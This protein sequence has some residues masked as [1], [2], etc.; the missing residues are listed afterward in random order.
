MGVIIYTFHPY[1]IGRGGRMAILEK[2]IN[3]LKDSGVVFTTV[4]AAAAEYEKDSP[5]KGDAAQQYSSR[6]G[7]AGCP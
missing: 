4:E 2:L 6:R 3:K 7:D 5:S 1:V